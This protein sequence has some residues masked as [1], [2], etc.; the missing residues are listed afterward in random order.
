M[1]HTDAGSEDQDRGA[2][3]PPSATEIEVTGGTIEAAP[4]IGISCSY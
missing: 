4:V 2:Y 1:P 3:E